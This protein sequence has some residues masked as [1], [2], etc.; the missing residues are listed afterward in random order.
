MKSSAERRC[1]SIFD[2]EILDSLRTVGVYLIYQNKLA[3]MIGPDKSGEKLGIVRLG[4]HIEKGETPLEAL[5]RELQEEADVKIKVI[6]ACCTYYLENWNACEVQI[7]KD[8]LPLM[9]PLAPWNL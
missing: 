3:F 1:L 2:V 4:G 9:V 8:E 7:V 5:E 6:D